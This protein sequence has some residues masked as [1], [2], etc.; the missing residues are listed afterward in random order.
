MLYLCVA[1]FSKL[2]NVLQC[3][4]CQSFRINPVA[5]QRATG[6]NGQ[7]V[8]YSPGTLMFDKNCTGVTLATFYKFAVDLYKK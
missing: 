4:G 7:G 8:K 3:V 5:K 6:K 2:A 1:P